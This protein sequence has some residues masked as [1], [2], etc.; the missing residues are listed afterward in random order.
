MNQLAWVPVRDVMRKEVTFI[1][2]RTDVLEAMRIMKR[3]K[4]T[5]LMV[6]KRD[7]QDEYGMLLFSDIAKQVIAKD[8]A[9]ERVNVYEI[10]AKPVISVRP[11]MNIRYCARL[12]D[13]FGISHAPVIENEEV[14]GIVS[15]YVIALHGLPNLD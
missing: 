1:A 10:M 5:V 11:D 15:Y 4:A 13:N 14:L 6:E 3:V 7:E 12:F 9:P 2:G 8:R